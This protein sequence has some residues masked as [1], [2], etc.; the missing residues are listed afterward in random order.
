MLGSRH[1]ARVLET[2]QEVVR[3]RE[4]TV[5]A[6]FL[7]QDASHVLSAQ[8]AAAVL[9][10]RPG[11]QAALQF[12]LLLGIE[13]RLCTPPRLICQTRQAGL[14]PARHPRRPAPARRLHPRGDLVGRETI[15]RVANHPQALPTASSLLPSDQRRQFGIRTMQSHRHLHDLRASVSTAR[16]RP[17]DAQIIALAEIAQPPRAVIPGDPY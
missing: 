5:D 13:G 10:P 8:R 15:E 6:E 1:Q 4:R 7:A 14:I 3:G 11:V 17:P 9:L 12:D 2:M 16:I